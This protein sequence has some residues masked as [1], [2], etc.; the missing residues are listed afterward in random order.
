MPN[1][2][3]IKYD[4]TQF[5]EEAIMAKKITFEVRKKSTSSKVVLKGAGGKDNVSTLKMAREGLGKMVKNG[6][7]P[8]G[9]LRC[10]VLENGIKMDEWNIAANQKNAP[11]RKIRT[12]K[13]KASPA[14][15]AS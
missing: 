14:A 10:A 12:T 8:K 5:V 3:I 7:L 4:I 2:V 1:C 13:K 15:K 11:I 6:K 9:V